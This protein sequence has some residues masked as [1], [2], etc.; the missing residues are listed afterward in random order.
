MIYAEAAVLAT[1]GLEAAGMAMGDTSRAM[2]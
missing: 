1:S 2:W